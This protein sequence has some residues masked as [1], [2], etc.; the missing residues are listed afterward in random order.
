MECEELRNSAT[1]LCG[2][3]RFVTGDTFCAW[4]GTTV[5]IPWVRLTAWTS[6]QFCGSEVLWVRTTCLWREV[7]QVLL[8]YGERCCRFYLFMTRGE[9]GPT[10]RAA[11]HARAVW[12]SFFP[13]D[14]LFHARVLRA[15]FMVAAAGC[16]LVQRTPACKQSIL[17]FS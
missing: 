5:T 15:S 4:W 13:H 12:L 11:I 17:I 8:V 6:T 2:P 16:A 7:L 14:F 9:T 10:L 3:E 1:L